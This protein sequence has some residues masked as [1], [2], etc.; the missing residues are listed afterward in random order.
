MKK[1]CLIVA[2]S[3]LAFLNV[4]AQQPFNIVP[5]PN[6]IIPAQGEFRFNYKTKIVAD[7][8]D[9]R[10]LASFLN[11]ALLKFHGFK[12]E[13]TPKMPK[14]NSISFTPSII[15]APAEEEVY[16]LTVNK[17]GIRIKATGQKGFYYGL[18]SLLQL[19]PMDFK[20]ET[21]IP[22]VQINDSP[23]FKYRGMHLDVGRH[24]FSVDFVKKYIDLMAQY[25]FNYFHWHL[26]EDQGWRIEIKKYPKLMEIGSKR[27]ET[28]KDKNF[29]P[30][31]GDGIPVEGF[32]TQEQIK[33]VVA[34]AKARYITVIPEIELP[35]HS[36]AALAAYPQFGCK[37]N[38]E[39]KPQTTWGIFKEVYCPTEETL[40]F[41]EDVLEE[42][43]ALFPDSP[44]IHIG[45]DE[46]LHDHWKE[47]EFVQALKAKEHLKN[48]NEV[49]SYIVRRMEK[50]INS[51]GK[52]IIGWDEIL[53][54]GIEP[55]AVIMSWRGEK[56]GIE[57]A[58][59][60]HQVIMTPTTYVYFDYGTGDPKTEPIF[61]GGY[62]P[63]EKIYN[64]DP[65]PKELSADEAKYILGAQANVWTEYM[66]TPDKVEYMAI[67]RMVA[68]SEALWSQ[69][70]I[71]DFSDFKN[72][73]LNQ[74]Q[75]LDKQK[76]NYR[77]QEPDGLKNVLL[78]RT[79]T[80]R[81]ELRPSVKDAKIYYTTDGSEPSESSTLYTKPFDI[82][83]EPGI[84][85]ELRTITKLPNG[86]KSTVQ[87]AV[88]LR[89]AALEPA[90]VTNREAGVRYMFFKGEFSSVKDVDA[91]KP[92]ESDITNSIQIQQF[93]KKTNDLKDSFGTIFDGYIF[94]PADDIYEFQLESKNGAVFVLGNEAVVDLDGVHDFKTATGIVPLKKGYYK[95]RLKYFQRGGGRAA[96]KLS[97][98]AKGRGLERI[99]GG[100]L[101]R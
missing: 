2:I 91:A 3:F 23:R 14:S 38:Y 17:N 34:Y 16:G 67:P 32:Y 52:R 85:I 74:Y 71:K 58:K 80:A 60:K 90:V 22:A 20:G 69:P 100:E 29:E 79:D 65:V 86:R 93:T 15:A 62:L 76:V 19:I 7:S 26:T 42:T 98:G 48:E 61:I 40:K 43:I 36:S 10:K 25:K 92:D 31:V 21:A 41:L 68:L 6:L 94:V 96:L 57:A 81:I 83:P 84:K 78:D 73:M 54:G 70:A 88:V 49:Q 56:G 9:K 1:L 46:V 12:L 101:W 28:M 59:A 45:G 55:S 63:L 11:D 50:F 87:S 27:K 72:R 99:W 77:I 37:Q 39:Y 44:Y 4:Y 47:S 97:W 51:K 13:V 35:G 89:R 18:Q 53:E 82:K 8:D 66:K 75:R 24:F 33:D 30:Y 95:F 5:K 64:Y